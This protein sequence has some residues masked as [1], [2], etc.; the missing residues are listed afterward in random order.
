[1][2]QP[3]GISKGTV[4]KTLAELEAIGEM[5]TP[6]VPAARLAAILAKAK[7]AMEGS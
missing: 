3:L 6:A 7:K 2:A 1:M 5:Q 4:A